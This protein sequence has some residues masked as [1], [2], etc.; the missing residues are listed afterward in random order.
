MSPELAETPEQRVG[1]IVKERRERLRLSQEEVK[2]RGGPSTTNMTAIENGARDFSTYTGRTIAGLEDALGWEQ[3]SID[4]ILEGGEAAL[5]TSA[6]ATPGL[7]VGS[8]VD[9]DAL[10]DALK[11]MQ[12]GLDAIAAMLQETRG[13]EGK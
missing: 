12:S 10:A 11:Q 3:G 1:R 7:P 8:R 9:P 4:R 2:S 13:P 5:R 6:P